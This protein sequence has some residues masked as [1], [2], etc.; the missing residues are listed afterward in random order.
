MLSK[1]DGFGLDASSTSRTRDVEGLKDII[2]KKLIKIE[3][4]CVREELLIK[5]EKLTNFID[6]QLRR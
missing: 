1:K 2:Y 3:R 5:L 6:K 4:F